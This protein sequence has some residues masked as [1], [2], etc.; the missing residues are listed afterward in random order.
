MTPLAGT[1]PK[2]PKIAESQAGLV[3]HSPLMSIL[4]Q[5]KAGL[6]HAC[7]DTAR[8]HHHHQF[9]VIHLC[10]GA[11]LYQNVGYLA[12]F[13]PERSGW[14]T[15]R[16]CKGRAHGTIGGVS[17]LKWNQLLNS[18]MTASEVLHICRAAHYGLTPSCTRISRTLLHPPRISSV[19]HR[20]A[21]RLSLLR[22]SRRGGCKERKEGAA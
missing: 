6:K 10:K 13:T 12:Q 14:G 8:E 11:W 18:L 17:W 16:C 3:P 21:G 2:P 15:A 4:L 22:S 5:R 19:Q 20:G 7:M 1:K 9:V